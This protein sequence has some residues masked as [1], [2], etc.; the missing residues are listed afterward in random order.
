[1]VLIFGYVPIFPKTLFP[2]SP[3]AAA[4]ASARRTA[5]EVVTLIAVEA[6]E[7]QIYGPRCCCDSCA[8][9]EK[10]CRAAAAYAT[11]VAT[12]TTAAAAASAV[13]LL[14]LLLLLLLSC[15][16]LA[17]VLLLLSHTGT[18]SP[19][20]KKKC[21]VLRD[22]SRSFLFSIRDYLYFLVI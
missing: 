13:L 5:S 9:K 10:A 21:A 1:M 3:A 17:A 16:L 6:L 20:S 22:A 19:C 4:D 11:S 18:S 2:A 14:L 8:K 12:A 7:V 15:C